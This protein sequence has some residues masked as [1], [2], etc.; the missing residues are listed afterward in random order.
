MVSQMVAA[1]RLALAHRHDRCCQL[2][3]RRCQANRAAAD[4][5]WC[6]AGPQARVF[7]RGVECGDE[8]ELVPSQL[9]YLA[10]CNLRCAF[11]LQE[12]PAID[13]LHGE[14]LTSDLLA[15]TMVAGRR[16]GARNL[17][18]VGGEPTVH[19]PAILDAMAGCDDLLPVIWKS[20]LYATPESIDLLDGIVDVYLA[21]LKFGND[22]CAQRIAGVPGY[23]AVVTRNLRLVAARG[24]LV[25]RHLLLPGHFDCCYR[26]VVDWLRRSMP[27]VKF[28][29]RTG[30]LP[31]WHAHRHP[32]LTRPLQPGTAD[33]ATALAHASQLNLIP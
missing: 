28:S 7:R 8:L 18:W 21:D 29:L 4:I 19:L 14:P 5:G 26:P 33:R 11:C 3:E 25:V 32:E 6:G 17:Q 31:R 27:Q 30:Y 13:P 10:G 23:W 20:N 1:E 15:E 12:E 2:C 22:Q 9:I 24:E 16:G